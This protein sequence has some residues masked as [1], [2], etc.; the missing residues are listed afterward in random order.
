MRGTANT[1]IVVGG[2]LVLAPLMY[3]YLCY[4]LLAQTAAVRISYRP[5]SGHITLD[6]PILPD[7]YVP[8]CLLI[9]TMCMGGGIFLAWRSPEAASLG[10][11]P[12]QGGGSKSLSLGLNQ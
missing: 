4:R 11:L 1:L 9:G 6:W 2:S 5:E 10:E 12:E 8:L 7:Y 3:T